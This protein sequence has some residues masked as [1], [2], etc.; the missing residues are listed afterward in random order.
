[1]GEWK[2]D[3]ETETNYAESTVVKEEKGRYVNGG[4][5]ANTERTGVVSMKREMD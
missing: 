1:M 3:N 5:F 4:K 2:R